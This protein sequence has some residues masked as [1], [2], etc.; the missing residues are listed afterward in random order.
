MVRDTTPPDEGQ[1]GGFQKGLQKENP[2][3]GRWMVRGMDGAAD[4]A[5]T[6]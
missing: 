6:I 4:G 5:V 2:G 1:L 3:G